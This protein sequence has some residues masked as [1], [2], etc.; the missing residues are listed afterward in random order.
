MYEKYLLR[1]VLGEAKKIE[2]L[3][4]NSSGKVYD[5]I[6]DAHKHLGQILELK[7]E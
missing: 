6:E 7:P 3:A 2:S 4:M 1:R 5:A